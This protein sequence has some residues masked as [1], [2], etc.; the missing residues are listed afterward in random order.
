MSSKSQGTVK[1]FND[2]KGFGFII[3][4]SGQEVFF[5]HKELLMDGYKRTREGEGVIF[6]QTETERGLHA[7]DVEVYESNW[8][9]ENDYKV[10]KTTAH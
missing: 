3:N 6:N 7:T 5:H 1:W 8:P 2:K 4:E 9:R 10:R